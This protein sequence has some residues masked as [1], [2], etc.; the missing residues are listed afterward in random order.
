MK[1]LAAILA[2]LAVL[3]VL[4][5]TPAASG[6][7]NVA[8]F[9][10]VAAD[11]QTGEVGLAVASRFFAVGSVV[12][13]GK[14]GVGAVAT[15]ASADTTFGPRGLELLARGALPQEIATVLL[16]GDSNADRRQFFREQRPGHC[17]FPDQPVP[18]VKR[19]VTVVVAS[20]SIPR[21]VSDGQKVGRGSGS[22]FLGSN[23]LIE[24]E[25]GIRGDP[26]PPSRQIKRFSL[27]V[28]FG[29]PFSQ[30]AFP[31]KINLLGKGQR[32]LGGFAGAG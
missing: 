10:I 9:S 16:R 27:E 24:R 19:G 25:A 13:Y 18:L 12:P 11:P 28:V 23:G 29:G 6:Q 7:P 1:A 30:E 31:G 22:L 14:A 2:V 15:Q 17:L 32:L 4:T 8:T 26:A 20:G 3:A 21:G 5:F